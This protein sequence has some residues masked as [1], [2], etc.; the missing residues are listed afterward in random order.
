MLSLAFHTI[1]VQ[2]YVDSVQPPLS[3]IPESAPDYDKTKKH[4]LWE[5]QSFIF[6]ILFLFLCPSVFLHLRL[7]P[8]V[9]FLHKTPCWF[10][11]ELFS[12]AVN[13]R[14]G[15]PFFRD[16]KDRLTQLLDYL[17]V[18]GPESGLFSNWSRNK[19]YLELSHDCLPVW[20]CAFR[21]KKSRKLTRRVKRASF[22]QL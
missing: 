10:C 13:L 7:R 3:E 15:V 4:R 22:C 1:G 16:E 21:S 6:L 19:R 14:S 5:L 18:A 12:I 2:G 11:V 20:Q 9:F 17:S 8:S